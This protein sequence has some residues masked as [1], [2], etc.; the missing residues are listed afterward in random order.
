MDQ[1]NPFTLRFS[2]DLESAFLEDYF[3]KSV[4][5]V[6][7]ALLL[8]ACLYGSF[9]VLDEFLDPG[10]AY[11]LWFVRY[12][13]VTPVILICF[14]LTFTSY[15]KKYMQLILSFSFLVSG[16]GNIALTVLAPEQHSYYAGLVLLL[17]YAYTFLR[18]RFIYATITSLILIVAYEFTVIW[19]NP[20][21]IPII[22]NNTFFIA[23]ANIIGMF[24]G[25]LLELY[26]RRD[27]LHDLLLEAEKEKSERLLLNILPESIAGRLKHEHKTIAEGFAEATVIFA[28]M[29]GFTKMSS[30]IPP[31]EV[32]AMLNEVFS[33]FDHLAE[34]H[35]VEKIK[36]IGDAYMGVGGL[37]VPRPDHA[38]AVA[39][40]ALDMHEEV[41]KINAE[42]GGS[43]SLR[44]GINSGPV[45]AG[46]IGTKKFIYDLW[47]DTVN[48]AS[49]MESH[50]V[51]GSI[52][53]TQD[54]YE[55]LK[56]KY[57][58]EQRGVIEVKGKGE[59]N[60]YL[61]TGRKAHATA[62]EHRLVA[63]SNPNVEV[64]IQTK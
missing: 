31:E 63:Q 46:V 28:D 35:G 47:G 64:Q 21:P 20:I 25:Y 26:L 55:R 14:F 56:G 6:R 60:T 4:K 30:K 16:L 40:L 39:E 19:I 57:E 7:F 12:L 52:Q 24:A 13:I 44:I 50:G 41:E 61:L 33:R 9:G 3:Q 29:A 2:G 58:F 53:V 43:L 34:K 17:M 22:L 38:E 27:F 37:P 45:V 1:M 32:V 5:H 23:S 54:T 59:M 15:F 10:A 18:L 36:T 49:R 11:Q 48:I 42:T 8:G 62:G 51:I